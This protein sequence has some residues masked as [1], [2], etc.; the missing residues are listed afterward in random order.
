MANQE[1][2]IG[3]WLKLVDQLVD[4]QFGA[5][6]EEHGVTRRQWQMMNLL[7]EGPATQKELSD[8]L[9]PFFPAVETGTSAELIEEL[10]E[11]GWVLLEDGQYQLTDLGSRS[12]ENL[13][14]AV[15]RIRQLMTDNITEEEYTALLAVLQ[16]MA[17]NL[18]WDGD[19]ASGP[20]V[21]T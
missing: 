11:S 20:R 14:G 15:D 5:S 13:R 18:G 4:D 19:V 8:G 21:D 9:R 2:P 3:F 10:R 12:L 16:R 1:R 7:V 6:F 17:S